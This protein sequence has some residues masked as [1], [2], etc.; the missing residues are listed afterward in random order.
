MVNINSTVS[1]YI[2]GHKTHTNKSKRIDIVQCLF[3]DQN[4]IK[5]EINNKHNKKISK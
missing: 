5:L 4:V 3:A 1:I 2:L